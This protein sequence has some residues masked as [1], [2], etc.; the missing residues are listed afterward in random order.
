MIL[1]QQTHLFS[2]G[3]DFAVCCCSAASVCPEADL[4]GPGYRRRFKTL[5]KLLLSASSVH[6][7]VSWS[8]L[9][10][11]RSSRW[12]C[13]VS[14]VQPWPADGLGASRRWSTWRS[15]LMWSE[16]AGVLWAEDVGGADCVSG[17]RP[18]GRWG[19]GGRSFSCTGRK[20]LRSL[21]IS[22]G[23]FSSSSN[24]EHLG[25]KFDALLGYL[26]LCVC[27]FSRAMWNVRLCMPVTPA[28]Q[29]GVSRLECVWPVHTSVMKVM[30]SL[31]ST[32]K[33]QHLA[34]NL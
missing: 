4:S 26:W 31:N 23:E 33:G 8:D 14:A 19:A 16:G 24:L 2:R 25:H 32:P 5:V 20:W 17:G 7:C 29:R 1:D 6:V 11:Y 9:W 27:V 21:L 13:L 15:F 10:R 22:S 30:T 28:H 18:G 3:S 12:R 34:L